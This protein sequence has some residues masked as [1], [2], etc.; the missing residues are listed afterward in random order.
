MAKRGGFG[1]QSMNKKKMM[2]QIEELQKQMEDAQEKVDNMEITASSGG[3]VVEVTVNGKNE[4]TKIKIDPEIL[5]PDDVE[6]IEDMLLVAANDAL[7]QVK[8]KSD[9]EMGK[10]TGGLNIPGF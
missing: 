2:K 10:L 7:K 6:M 8:A 1:Q 5:D 3:G 4:L 9:K